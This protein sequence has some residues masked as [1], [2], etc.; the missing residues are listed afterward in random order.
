[1]LSKVNIL[2]EKMSFMKNPIIK[3]LVPNFIKDIYVRLK[4]QKEAKLIGDNTIIWGDM[5]FKHCLD[6]AVKS[7]D[8]DEEKLQR[9][10]PDIKE[11]YFIYGIRP[12]E[13]FMFKFEDKSAKERKS[14]LSDKTKDE[15]L[16]QYYGDNWK[17]RLDFTK[18]KYGF[19]QQLKPFY[20]RDII[21]VSER[22]D[23]EMFCDFCKHHDSFIV[24]PLKGGGGKGI[25]VVHL[26]N[27]D[28]LN[29]VFD[30]LITNGSCVIEE[31]IQQDPRLSEFNSSSLNTVRMP[32]FRHGEV[33]RLGWPS[34][35][36]GRNGSVVDNAASG[37]VFA[38][39][40][41]DS[42][43]L[44]TDAQDESG[45]IFEYHPDSK[46][47]FKGYKIPE[48][49]QLLEVVKSAHLSLSEEDVYIAFDVALSNK[50]WV[51][52]EG[53]WGDIICQQIAMKRGLLND[54]VDLLNNG[55]K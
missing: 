35:R 20:K 48:W 54:F 10:L 31:L 23:Y 46:K 39:V 16:M 26:Q 28:Q 36:F 5:T 12:H 13:Y 34:M 51:I 44:L 45:H 8:I 49:N 32:S 50:G 1:M 3:A 18:N 15:L 22:N 40:N 42:G 6:N 9:L 30:E 29:Q 52:V 14:Y 55:N 4:A 19:Y 41:V 33:V 2:N 37:G 17:S 21:L 24:K 7:F 47:K 11:S 43:E 53:N 27:Q 38:F 25:R